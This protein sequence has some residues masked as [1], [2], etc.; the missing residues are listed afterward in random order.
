MASTSDAQS[1]K[2]LN[3]NN[4]H[5]WKMMMEF[6]LLEKDLLEITLGEYCHQKLKLERL[7][8]KETLLNTTCS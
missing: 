6:L 5:T 8:L 3:D 1:I 7:F 4:F 2:K